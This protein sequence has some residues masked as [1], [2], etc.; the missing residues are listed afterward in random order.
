[1][2]RD[3][4]AGFARVDLGGSRLCD[5]ALLF[6][7]LLSCVPVA[8][9]RDALSFALSGAGMLVTALAVRRARRTNY[10]F[11]ADGL[12]LECGMKGSPAL[13]GQPVAARMGR[14]W[15]SFTVRRGSGRR[16]SSILLF[17]DQFSDAADYRRF[18]LWLRS[19]LR[20][21]EPGGDEGWS[22]WRRY[23]RRD[24]HD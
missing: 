14:C 2:N 22:G 15:V 19:A 23:W 13:S 5:V 12:A 24:S 11:S 18:R 6:L 7:V 16:R 4:I 8:L 21:D 9:H 20:A 1:M 17:S 10:L 3:T